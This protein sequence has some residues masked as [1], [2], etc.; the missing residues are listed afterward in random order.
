MYAKPWIKQPG[1]W[2]SSDSIEITDYHFVPILHSNT[3]AA[4]KKSSILNSL[5]GKLRIQKQ[6]VFYD[7]F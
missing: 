7:Y 5:I 3:T 2:I 1:F 4:C 6:E